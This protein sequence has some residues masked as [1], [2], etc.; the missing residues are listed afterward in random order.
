[1]G[2][3]HV[4]RRFSDR[5]SSAV[6]ETEDLWALIDSTGRSEHELEDVAR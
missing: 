1:M 2:W 5:V 3:V 4:L 6:V